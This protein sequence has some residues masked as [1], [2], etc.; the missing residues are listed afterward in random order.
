MFW[1]AESTCLKGCAGQGEDLEEAVRELEENETVWLEMAGKYDVEIP[2]VPIE[3]INEY[4]GKFTVRVS[5]AA[6]QEAAF[7]AQKEGVSLNQYV[8]DA[9]VAQNARFNTID[10]IVPE[11][12][13]AIEKVQK[14][15][16]ENTTTSGNWN[17]KIMSISEIRA[18]NK[19][20]AMRS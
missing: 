13:N 7:Y 11:I 6:H 10:R 8:S 9:I 3:T 19:Q 12:K 5:P 14:L 20:T 4:S 15:A 1:A 16:Y 17:A 18:Y 2:K